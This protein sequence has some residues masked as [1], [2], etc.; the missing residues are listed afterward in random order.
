MNCEKFK[1]ILITDYIDGELSRE[2]LKTA[3]EHLSACP[4]CRQFKEDLMKNAVNPFKAIENA[5]PPAYVWQNIRTAIAENSSAKNHILSGFFKRHMSF[6][7]I[8]AAAAAVILVIGSSLYFSQPFKN[9][10]KASDYS[11][12][13]SYLAYLYEGM[14]NN[15]AEPAAAEDEDFLS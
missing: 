15:E 5:A 6:P 13:E 8:S 4:D 12:D 2:Q 10:V 11:A 9:I 1:E 3:D 14:E 7:V